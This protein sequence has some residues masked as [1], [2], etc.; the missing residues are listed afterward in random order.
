MGNLQ[1]AFDGGGFNAA[2]VAPQEDFGAIPSGEYP[3]II[4]DSGWK[5][6]KDKKGRYVELVMVIIDGPYKNR[7]LWTRLNL[8]NKNEQTVKIARAQLSSICHAVDILN[9]EDTAELHNKPMLARVEFRTADYD[10]NKNPQGSKRETNEVRNWKK[11][12]EGFDASTIL[13]A[14]NAQFQPAKSETAKPAETRPSW[15]RDAA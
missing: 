14:H 3:V 10:A 5:E 15:K 7:K 6:T 12:P 1:N 4:E 8:E 13:P 9:P 2:D 11:L